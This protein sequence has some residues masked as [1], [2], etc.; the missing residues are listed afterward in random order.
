MRQWLHTR[1]LGFE[2]PA[3]GEWIEIESPY[4]A[5]LEFALDVLRAEG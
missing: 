5:D 4:P 2:H 3:T 1:A